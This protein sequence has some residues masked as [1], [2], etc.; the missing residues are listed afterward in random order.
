MKSG[1][2][3]WMLAG[4]ACYAVNDAC[5]KALGGR[6]PTGELLALRGG[7][8]LL[9]LMGLASVR[10]LRRVGRRPSMRATWSTWMH[11]AVWL[12]C[13]MEV[14]AATCAVLALHRAP[15]AT[16]TAILQCAP[17]LVVLAS[18]ALGWEP[19]RRKHVLPVLVGLSG[20]VLVM[21]VPFAP[22][23]QA[24]LMAAM[25][26]A[27]SLAGRD[28][29]SRRL[30]SL[31]SSTAVAGLSS[32]L[33][34]VMGLGLGWAMK[35]AWQ[36]PGAADWLLVAGTACA[37]AAGNSLVIA[38]TRSELPSVL[39]PVRYS[40]I[41]WSC[42]IAYLGWGEIP[43]GR[44]LAGIALIVVGGVLALRARGPR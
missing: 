18:I 13:A 38:A 20:A 3:G 16:V 25:A 24:G 11:G 8:S 43:G 26:C 27:L 29:A 21:Q 37:S 2:V 36:T 34:C 32:G 5:I 22:G 42:L 19:L 23:T 30:P 31:A 7:L 28:L 41:A 14:S 1:P 6:I 10:S 4:M 15:M 9:L 12:R 44:E 40:L 17:M 39:A 35:Q 33:T